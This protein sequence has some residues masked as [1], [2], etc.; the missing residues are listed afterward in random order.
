MK[1][2]L[3]ILAVALIAGG[4]MFAQTRLSIGV[5]IGGYGPGRYPP[6]VY[7]Q[8]APPCPGPGYTWVDGYWGP[9]GG[10]NVWF[11]G[12][13]NRPYVSGYR[14]A[15][16]F[17]EPRSYNAYRGYERGRDH[18]N[19]NRFQNRGNQRNDNRGNQRS[20]N[21]GNGYANGFRR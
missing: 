20:E 2:Q 8:Y 18:G 9:Q 4:S 19:D 15:P 16:R 7:A 12:Y 21:R 17:V 5:G 13:W 14:V 3:R 11:D 1:T 10:R 6:P